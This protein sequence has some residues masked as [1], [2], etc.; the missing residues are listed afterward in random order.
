M[1]DRETLGKLIGDAI[2]ASPLSQAEIVRRV[3][4]SES[5]MSK[6]KSGE[7]HIPKRTMAAL[8]KVLQLPA[9]AWD[10]WKQT[11]NLPP[12]Q[13]LDDHLA[14]LASGLASLNEAQTE[15]SVRQREILQALTRIEERLATP[16]AG[17]AEN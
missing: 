15:M 2:D 13:R 5:S 7:R 12:R 1:N 3:K 8:V 14:A 11:D 17:Q 4:T 10:L 16:G 9:D 6:Y